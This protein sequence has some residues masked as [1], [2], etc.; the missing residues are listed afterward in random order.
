MTA[1]M[2]TATVWV[3]PVQSAGP[4]NDRAG[5][6]HSSKRQPHPAVVSS[7]TARM[8][9]SPLSFSL[10]FVISLSVPRMNAPLN[11]TAAAMALTIR[12]AGHEPRGSGG[13][14]VDPTDDDQETQDQEPSPFTSSGERGRSGITARRFRLGGRFESQMRNRDT[15]IAA[16]SAR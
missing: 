3:Q 8:F 9:R 7:R 4:E 13:K 10:I 6:G 11:M 5:E 2:A 15:P 16:A 12:T 14:P 1:E